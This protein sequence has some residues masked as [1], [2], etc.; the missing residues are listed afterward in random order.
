VGILAASAVVA[1]LLIAVSLGTGGGGSRT[2]PASTPQ[3]DVFAG[4]PQHGTVLGRPSAPVTLH[5]Y[6]DLQC[7]YCAEW[8]RETL[9]SVVREY[10]RTGRLKLDFRGLGFIG[11]DSGKALRAVFAAGR[12]G[13]LWQLLDGLYSVQGGENSGWVTDGLLRESAAKAG[14]DVSKLL[15]D[16][17]RVDS[18]VRGAEADARAAGVRST[19]TF[20]LVQPSGPPLRLQLSGLDPGSFRGAIEQY[21]P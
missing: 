17:D 3:A 8:S 7:P 19:P 15:A 21:L 20:A 6:A 18:D 2:T 16:M 4:I 14:L 11:P 5:E 9:P 10:V 13:K 12:Q 1:G